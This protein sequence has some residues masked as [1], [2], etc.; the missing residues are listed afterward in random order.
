MA[1][2]ERKLCSVLR[3]RLSGG[4]SS[5]S[6]LNY[7]SIEGKE[8]KRKKE[9]GRKRFKEDSPQPTMVLQNKYK[10]RASRRY[11][12][13]RGGAAS[14]RG[15]GGRGRGGSF[16]SEGSGSNRGADESAFPQL[17]NVKRGQD[18]E[19]QED[20]DDSD[21]ED[22]EGEEEDGEESENDDEGDEG[23]FKGS[24]AERGKYSRRKLESN[25]WR[26]AEKEV[27]PHGV[28]LACLILLSDD[29]ADHL[30]VTPTEEKE[31]SEPEVDLTAL[32]EKVSK[33]DSSRTS[34]ALS[35]RKELEDALA[36][37]RDEDENDV[38]HTL[39]HLLHRQRIRGDSERKSSAG[40]RIRLDDAELLELEREGRRLQEE[41][42]K[43][44]GPRAHM[45]RFKEGGERRGIFSSPGAG[46][47]IS[48]N[49]GSGRG[50]EREADKAEVGRRTVAT[51]RTVD[52]SALYDDNNDSGN[53]DDLDALLE[54]RA[55]QSRESAALRQPPRQDEELPLPAQDALARER[56]R[57]HGK[58]SVQVLHKGATASS[59]PETHTKSGND[60]QDFLDSVL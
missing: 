35:S 15:R 60:M 3:R 56:A 11:N 32:R 19:G 40:S 50:K 59:R 1:E 31:E 4:P 13:A 9:K 18:G 10:A 58:P 52:T 21:E 22:D 27:D 49:I 47:T 43:A 48:L 54:A 39:S 44:Q 28:S 30:L 51:R 57:T 17:G 36:K 34:N 33:L 7:G 41:K 12:A 16:R 46:K 5:S 42:E 8:K 20:G 37:Q 24:S 29:N 2:G 26:Y 23:N 53:Q 45:E 38:D 6:R 14:D 25:A 55:S